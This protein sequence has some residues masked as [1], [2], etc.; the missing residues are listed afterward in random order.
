MDHEAETKGR[1]SNRCPK[2]GDVSMDDVDGA[3][4]MA[5]AETIETEKAAAQGL[6]EGMRKNQR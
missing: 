6:C 1:N 5:G 3:L 4:M 2:R